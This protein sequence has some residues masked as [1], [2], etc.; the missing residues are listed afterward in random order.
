R[1]SLVTLQAP[2][3]ATVLAWRPGSAVPRA[4]FAVALKGSRTYE[5]VVDLVARRVV[6]WEEVQGAQPTFLDEELPQAGQIALGDTRF[7]A[8]LRRRGL[9]ADDVFCIGLPPATPASAEEQNR[10]VAIVFCFVTKN[11]T[12]MPWGRMVGGLTAMVDLNTRAVLRVQDDGVVPI[13]SNWARYDSAAVGPTRAALPPIQVTQ[14]QGAGFRVVGHQV[15]W[16]NWSFH[17]RVDPRVGLV[18]SMVRYRDGDRWRSVMYEGSLSEMFVPYMDPAR[19]FYAF[20]FMDAG[21][22]SALG[23]TKPLVP[24]ADCPAHALYFD[25]VV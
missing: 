3:K 7:T 20:S 24:G 21:E 18:L 11:A 25:A 6:R 12:T 17:Y 15:S 22:F 5:A 2:Y 23:I 10:R 9:S 16:D 13:P 1:Y 14:P 19:P 8:A 4:A